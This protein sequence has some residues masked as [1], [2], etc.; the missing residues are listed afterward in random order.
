MT[1]PT[2]TP[3]SPPSDG[4]E[5]A[6]T[7]ALRRAGV[8]RL[9]AT[10]FAPPTPASLTEVTERAATLGAA[11][12]LEAAEAAALRALGAAADRAEPA[13]VL[14]EHGFLFDRQVRCPPY[15]GAYG[16]L[17]PMSA[18]KA[19]VLADLAGFYAAFGLVPA[20]ARPEVEDHLVAELEFMSALALKE[21]W[22]R[23]EDH[24]EGLAVTRDAEAAFLRDHLGRWVDA[25]AAGLRQATPLPYYAAAADALAAWIRADALALGVEPPPLVGLAPFGPAE[26]EAFSCPMAAASANAADPSPE[27]LAQ[28]PS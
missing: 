24:A 4:R 5:A 9:L 28:G 26:A 11:Q 2:V 22:A 8:Y 18:G 13:A 7:R 23:L 14:E 12:A 1:A 21:A 25:F 10:A 19:A 6:V 16:P 20:A 15:E 3:G 17:D 27:R